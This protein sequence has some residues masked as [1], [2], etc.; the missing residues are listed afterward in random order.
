MAR[1][2]VVVAGFG[3]V[4]LN[5]GSYFDADLEFTWRFFPRF[6]LFYWICV[7]WLCRHVL[8]RLGCVFL[9]CRPFAWSS[10]LG[11]G[12][13]SFRLLPPR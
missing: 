10:A 6:P 8:S 4:C 11:L 12:F 2:V 9:L 1:T 13:C 3:S 5:L 7:H